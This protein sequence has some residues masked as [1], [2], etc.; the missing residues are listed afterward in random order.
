MICFVAGG[1]K[2]EA[3]KLFKNYGFLV[4][5]HS[6]AEGTFR[7][8]SRELELRIFQNFGAAAMIR[9]CSENGARISDAQKQLEENSGG[10]HEAIV[11]FVGRNDVMVKNSAGVPN[12]NSEIVKDM[13]KLC[14]HAAS[15]GRDVFI[16]TQQHFPKEMPGAERKNAKVDLINKCIAS[17]AEKYGF[18][19]IDIRDAHVGAMAPDMMH[20]KK[21]DVLREMFLDSVR[22]AYFK[23]GGRL[24]MVPKKEIAP[25]A[26]T[27][28]AEKKLIAKR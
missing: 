23:N 7:R 22:Q 5:G 3:G 2:K 24:A 16:Y 18:K 26:T 1:G 8:H 17:A 6:W 19:V 12:K 9:V 21:Y 14:A 28:V 10:G 20:P 25:P 4:V 13:E 11:I 15:L 27:G